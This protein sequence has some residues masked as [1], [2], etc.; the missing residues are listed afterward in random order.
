MDATD[1]EILLAGL[2]R[3]F[4]SLLVLGITVAT[5]YWAAERWP[6]QE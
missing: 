5:Y 2:T 6:P 3:C 4:R 1:V